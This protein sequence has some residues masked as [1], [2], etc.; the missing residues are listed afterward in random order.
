MAFLNLPNSSNMKSVA[1]HKIEGELGKY[2][3][4]M[5]E[6]DIQAAFEEEVYLTLVKEGR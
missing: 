6:E 3:Q 2:I 4:S 5:A 1:F